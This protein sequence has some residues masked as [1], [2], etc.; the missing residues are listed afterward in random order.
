MRFKGKL[1]A[2]A[3]I[4]IVAACGEGSGHEKGPDVAG[5]LHVH[6]TFS[7][8]ANADGTR[9]APEEQGPAACSNDAPEVIQELAWTSPIWYRPASRI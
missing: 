4:V 3:A 5:D 2:A 8:D 6:S 1:S 7:W 9:S